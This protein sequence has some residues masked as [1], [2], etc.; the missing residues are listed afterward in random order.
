MSRR[1][2]FGLLLALGC[3]A[4]SFAQDHSP[5]NVPQAD[6]VSF[7]PPAPEPAPQPVPAP[8]PQPLWSSP[9][10]GEPTMSGNDPLSRRLRQ[11][12]ETKLAIRRKAEEKAAQRGERLA[13]LQWYGLSNSRPTASSMPFMGNY[14]PSWTNVNTGR[15]FW[16]GPGRNGIPLGAEPSM[17]P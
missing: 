12:E 7:I 6:G 16:A 4:P 9:Q 8:Q 14:S 2:A 5:L 15:V 11:Q 13:V 17:V 3:A 1:I 10:Q